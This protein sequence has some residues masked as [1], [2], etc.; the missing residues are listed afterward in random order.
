M[1]NNNI[2]KGVWSFAKGVIGKSNP[3]VGMA[4]GAVEGVVRQVKDNKAS[5]VGGKGQRDYA[6][7]IGS[8]VGGVV[9]I[10]GSYLVITGQ[11]DV[12]T[13]KDL[14]KIVN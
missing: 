2:L 13:L 5:D 3:V 12:Q 4:L 8:I 9:A 6:G 10:Y 11:L 1:K 14:M 7:L